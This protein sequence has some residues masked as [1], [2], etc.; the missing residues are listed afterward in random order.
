MVH[1][2]GYFEEGTRA[3]F[4]NDEGRTTLLVD[5]RHPNIREGWEDRINWEFWTTTED[6]W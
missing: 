3:Y 5:D 2:R 6:E 4:V 1:V